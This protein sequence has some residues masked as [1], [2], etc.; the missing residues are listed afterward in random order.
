MRIILRGRGGGKTHEILNILEEDPRAICFVTTEIERSHV[1]AALKLRAEKRSSHFIR[2][3]DY[4]KKVRILGKDKLEGA[5]PQEH[6]VIDNVDLFLEKFLQGT[7]SAVTLT[8]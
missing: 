7:V 8:K 5:D 2:P 6:A 1:I 4:E 3:D